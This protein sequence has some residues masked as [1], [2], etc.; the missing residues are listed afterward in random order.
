MTAVCFD[1]DG[2]LTDPKLGITG[3]IRHALKVLGCE[4]P[5]GDDL[6]W[7]IGPP[8]LASFETLLGDG[9]DAVRALEIYRERFSEIGL[10]E[11]EIYP[12]I[13]DVLT[14]LT[15]DGRQL[16]VAT[17]KPAVYAV[18]IIEHFELTEFFD[19]VYGAELDGTRSDKTELLSYILA[20][21]KLDVATTFMVGDRSFDIIG[22]RNNGMKAIGVL[23]G[24]GSKSELLDAGAMALC[25]APQ[26]LLTYLR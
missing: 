20:Q 24:F 26:D 1:L 14:S 25:D 22:A 18:R 16:F 7:C 11:N 23:Y 2:T 4:V 17:S 5:E 8:L 13:R 12:G 9:C 19:E 21:Q 3:S 6:T 10:F 15:R